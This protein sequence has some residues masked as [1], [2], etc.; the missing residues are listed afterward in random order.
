MTSLGT[1]TE[2]TLLNIYYLSGYVL[3]TTMKAALCTAINFPRNVDIRQM[4]SPQRNSDIYSYKTHLKTH[5][6]NS[7]ELMLTTQNTSIPSGIPI[8]TDSTVDSKILDLYN[9]WNSEIRYSRSYIKPALRFSI[10]VNLM[11]DYVNTIKI[12]VRELNRLI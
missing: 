4:G 10:D 1:N 9:S 7:I 2:K 12:I 5:S 6:L 3:E 8:I 11:K